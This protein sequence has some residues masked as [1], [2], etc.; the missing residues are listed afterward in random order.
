MTNYIL[1]TLEPLMGS[2][3]AQLTYGYFYKELKS[4]ISGFY[5]Y[6]IVVAEGS[7]NDIFA[8]IRGSNK[9]PF[10]IISDR[11]VFGYYT[12]STFVKGDKKYIYNSHYPLTTTSQ[13][14]RQLKEHYKA[15]LADKLI[16]SL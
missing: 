5:K 11:S 13:P 1:Y 8:P 14:Y 2:I 12:S 9:S 7:V 10:L 6:K 15:Y 16:E 3:I 4:N